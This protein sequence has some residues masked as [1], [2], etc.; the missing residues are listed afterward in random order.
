MQ[1]LKE[2]LSK[3]NQ[4][5]DEH[6]IIRNVHLAKLAMTTTDKRLLTHIEFRQETVFGFC[7]EFFYN[8]AAKLDYHRNTILKSIKRLLNLTLIDKIPIRIKGRKKYGYGLTELGELVLALLDGVEELAKKIKEFFGSSY[9]SFFNSKILGSEHTPKP[10]P[11]PS[12]E[13]RPGEISPKEVKYGCNSEG[14]ARNKEGT[15]AF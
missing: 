3:F 13:H 5:V 1:A 15:M 11:K 10:R 14:F 9:F 8:I 7:F 4:R 12:A 2:V 6:N